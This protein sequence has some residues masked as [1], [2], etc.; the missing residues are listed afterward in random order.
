MNQSRLRKYSNTKLKHCSSYKKAFFD[1]LLT[2]YAV[3]FVSNLPI[4]LWCVCGCVWAC[5]YWGGDCYH[6]STAILQVKSPDL[7]GANWKEKEN[8]PHK[9]NQVGLAL[10]RGRQSHYYVCNTE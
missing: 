10:P 9:L 3:F 5:V 8:C 2:K 4:Q 7:H 1:I 6:S